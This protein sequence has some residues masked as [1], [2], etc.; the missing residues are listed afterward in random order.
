VESGRQLV[1]AARKGNRSSFAGLIER[2]ERTV[3][4]VAPNVLRDRHGASDV[5]QT[6]FVIAYRKLGA[7]RKPYTISGRSMRLRSN[8]ALHGEM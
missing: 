2:Y 4:A 8:R 1:E 6:V 7:F 5:A 3:R